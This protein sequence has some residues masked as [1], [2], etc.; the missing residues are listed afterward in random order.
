MNISVG[1][2]SKYENGS[3]YPPIEALLSLARYYGVDPNYLLGWDAEDSWNP[4]Q[5]G[6][7]LSEAEFLTILETYGKMIYQE[8]MK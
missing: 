2:I 3:I 5:P 8:L 1:M 6:K 7:A 4:R